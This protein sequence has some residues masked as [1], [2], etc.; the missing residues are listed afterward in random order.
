M[1]PAKRSSW[2]GLSSNIFTSENVRSSRNFCTIAR[3]SGTVSPRKISP[4]PYSHVP[5]LKN[6]ERISL[7]SGCACSR[8]RAWIGRRFIGDYLY[9][10]IHCSSIVVSSSVNFVSFSSQCTEIQIGVVPR[11]APSR[12]WRSARRSSFDQSSGMKSMYFS[13][14]F[15]VCIFSSTTFGEGTTS[16]ASVREASRTMRHS[17]R[18]A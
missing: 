17:S 5:V 3:I 7:F 18:R 6:R 4:S 14:C 13:S 15:G 10:R 1:T 9:S 2:Y 12:N 11:G 16:C 8:R